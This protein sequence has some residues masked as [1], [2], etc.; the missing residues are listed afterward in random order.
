M[1][2]IRHAKRGL[3]ALLLVMGALVSIAAWPSH[4]GAP[5]SP[6]HTFAGN[7]NPPIPVPTPNTG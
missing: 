7:A 1:G 4:G 3:A 5:G 2:R 6:T